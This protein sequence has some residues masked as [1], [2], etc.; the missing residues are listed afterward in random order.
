MEFQQELYRETIRQFP[1]EIVES[2]HILLHN[3]CAFYVSER[4]FP[5][6]ILKGYA[7]TGKTSLLSAF[8][9]ALVQLKK[10]SVLLAPT[11][12]AA[13]V[14]SHYSGKS[15]FTIHK[16][17][18]RKTKLDGGMIQLGIAPNLHTNTLFLVDEASMIGDYTMQNDGSISP[19]N[20]LEDLI[21]Y[22]YQGKNCKLIL[23]GDEGQLPPVGS[24]YS[25]A[26]N[27]EY[28]D[29]HFPTLSIEEHQLTEVLRQANDSD[30]LMNA[31]LLRSST[32]NRYPHFTLRMHN[33][34][35]RLNGGDLQE[36][37]ENAFSH[38]GREETIVITRSNKRANLFNQQ[39]RNRIFWYEE[40]I[41]SSD[42]LM[43]V[44]NNYFWL[45]D[46]AEHGFIA[47]GE[48]I[49]VTRV[50]NSENVYGFD[51]MNVSIRMPDYEEYGIIEVKLLLN[52]LETET[53][54]L[55][56]DQM[57]ELFFEVE[58]EYAYEKNKKKRYELIMNDPYMNALQVKY[59]YAVTCHKSQGGQWGCVFVDQ[60]FLTEDMLDKS[61]FRWLYT[62]LTRATEKLY[63][64]N[65]SDE[66]FK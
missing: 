51:F 9:K 60:G 30:I 23:I 66:F 50:R 27:A 6:F 8:V 62:A 19:R 45:G 26:L 55:S 52:T 58:K 18:Y 29:N 1:H 11:G 2:Q 57:K 3:L 38:Y 17:I 43:V 16:K 12:R 65:F 35:I 28:L 15:A 21:N 53:P 4:N 41:V 63:L 5:L 7:G 56:R 40:K 20:L 22:V 24:D 37:L 64:V 49:E 33:D 36:E 61:F 59:A 10:K 34:L 47:N 48:I 32:E 13:K 54:N 31:T 25:P 42:L 14:F 44:K 39:I 46:K